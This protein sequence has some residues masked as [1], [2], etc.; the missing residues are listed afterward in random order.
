MNDNC[1]DYTLTQ[2]PPSST[3]VPAG[4]NIITMTVTDA[5]SNQTSCTFQLNVIETSMPSIA[6]PANIT[7]CDTLVTY[8][9]PAATDNCLYIVTQTDASGL[10]SGSIF[11]PGLTTQT[12]TVTDSSGNSESC[13]FTVEVLEIPDPAVIAEDTIELCNTFTSPV[14]AGA[15]GSG[16]GSWSVIQGSGTF[17]DAA[18]NSTTVNGLGIGTNKLMWSVSSPSCGTKTDTVAVIVWPLPTTAQVQ[19]TLVTCTGAGV[20]LQGSFPV[21]GI[22][23]WT[24]TGGIVFNDEHA[25]VTGITNLDGGTHTVAWTISSGTCP[26]SSDTMVI[27]LPNVASINFADTSLCDS[28]FPLQLQGS[29]PSAGQNVVWSSLTGEA[30]FSNSYS[31]GTTITGTSFG[32]IQ[33][34]YWLTHQA[35]GNSTDTLTL[36]VQDCDGV[37]TGIPTMFTPNGDSRNDYFDIPNLGI[38]YPGCRVEIYN[39]WGGLVFESDGYTVMW[40]GTFKGEHVPMGTYFYHVRLNDDAN[41]E[42]EGSISII[43]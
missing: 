38:N 43:R 15:I 4:T 16:T 27:E 7:S 6:C 19:D 13:S 18:S 5:G 8:T 9:T 11:P 39:R 40:D 29:A 30:S 28:D 12:W 22:G 21:N 32:S 26:V 42:L 20:L 35:C 1:P 34:I 2:T 17:A 41:T 3:V 37:I 25:A 10:T 24:T 36:T 14:F 33:I 23:T 31:A